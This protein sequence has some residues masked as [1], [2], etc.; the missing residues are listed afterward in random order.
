MCSERS[1]SRAGE[2]VSACTG[3]GGQQRL[4]VMP[5]GKWLG[6]GLYTASTHCHQQPPLGV[7]RLA[8]EVSHSVPGDVAKQGALISSVS[9]AGRSSSEYC[10]KG[11]HL[12]PKVQRRQTG[13]LA[14][15][16]SLLS[17]SRDSFPSH[18]H[19][20][21]VLALPVLFSDSSLA[22][23]MGHPSQAKLSKNF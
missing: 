5:N 10:G 6:L 11:S 23:I 1:T 16:Y 18:Q 7:R 13:R 17:L 21:M 3:V 22:C 12:F 14:P 2:L 20:P 15:Q 19:F 8:V 9:P 4:T